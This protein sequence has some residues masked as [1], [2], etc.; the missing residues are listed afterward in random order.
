MGLV[1]LADEGVQ[2][3]LLLLLIPALG[4]TFWETRERS[5]E[6]RPMWWWLSLVLVLHVIGYLALR[7]WGFRKDR[8]SS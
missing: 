8:A 6:S 7:L 2:T 4:L 1:L 3:T 5:M